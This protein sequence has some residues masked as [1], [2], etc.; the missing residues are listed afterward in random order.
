M[1]TNLNNKQRQTFFMRLALDQAKKNLGN[2]AENPSVGCVIT[3]KNSVISAGYTGF[4]GRPHAEHFAI[5]NSKE[6][7]TNSNLYVTLEPCSHHGKTPP[8]INKIIKNKIK[9]VYFSIRDPDFRS[10]NKSKDKLMKFNVSVNTGILADKINKF[11]S[12]Y[13]LYKKNALPF[14]TCKLA[15]S[16]D[17]F[18]INKKKK[19][20]TNKFSR[21]R[22]HLMRSEH[23]LI[24]TSSKTIK[25]D[26]PLL[27]CRINGLEKTSPSR[28][29]LDNNLKI[30]LNSN[31][32]KDSYKY[33]T[34]I[35]YN[36]NNKR[37]IRLLKNLGVKIYKIPINI[38]GDLDLKKVLIQAK[39]LGFSRIFLESGIKLANNFL[40]QNLVNELKIFVS[41]KKLN[42]D[43][44]GNIKKYFS[45]LLRGKRYKVEKVNLLKEK[46]ISYYIKDV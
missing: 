6:K 34:I 43:G 4:K 11:Y 20:I 16:K 36:K 32:I 39:R 33:R 24:I 2:T 42:K 7:L 9:K 18:T 45:N 8:C 28:I 35:F 30:P 22:V 13:I 46:L 44:D 3:K 27:N 14:V 31:V 23:D 41:D 10:F 1:S 26:N 17:Y 40:K 5:I 12:S 37:K 38:D 21:G 15:V 29:I 19:W 25:I